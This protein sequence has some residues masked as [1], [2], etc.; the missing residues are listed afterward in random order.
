MGLMAARRNCG[1]YG[2][3]FVGGSCMAVCPLDRLILDFVYDKM[4]SDNK[5]MDN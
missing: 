5:M 1:S 4:I 2:A 3:V